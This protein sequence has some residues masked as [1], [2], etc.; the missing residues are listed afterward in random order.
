[1]LQTAADLEQSGFG[2]EA[3]LL[4]GQAAIRLESAKDARRLLNRAR[5]LRGMA[6]AAG[7]EQSTQSGLSDREIEVAELILDGHSYKEIGSRLFISAKTVEHHASHIR[8]KLDAVG[9]PRAVFLAALKADL[10]N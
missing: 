4:V 6:S 9:V 5:E 10:A 1:M 7:P 8:Q 2:S 3:A